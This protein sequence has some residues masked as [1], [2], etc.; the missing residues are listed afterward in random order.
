MLREKAM[1]YG[2]ENSS[3]AQY[4]L[5]VPGHP[6]GG[7]RRLLSVCHSSAYDRDYRSLQT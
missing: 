7:D 5:F 4:K 1:E 3:K 6:A 2:R